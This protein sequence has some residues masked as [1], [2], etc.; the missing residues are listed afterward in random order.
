M[1]VEEVKNEEDSNHFESVK[2]RSQWSNLSQKEYMVQ[3][4]PS[5]EALMNHFSKLE[6]SKHSIFL[7][8][9]MNDQSLNYQE[10]DLPKI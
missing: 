4:S 10:L 7:E 5:G 9:V 2:D 1:D 3:L 8:K 6:E